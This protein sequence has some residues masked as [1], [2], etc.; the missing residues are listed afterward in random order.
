[1]LNSLAL[2]GYLK[3]I[4]MTITSDANNDVYGTL[5]DNVYCAG[6]G[7]TALTNTLNDLTISV[8]VPPIVLL[9]NTPIIEVF[10]LSVVEAKILVSHIPGGIKRV[11]KLYTD[12]NDT[13]LLFD[14]KE[15]IVIILVVC[16]VFV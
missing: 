3:N 5:N 13:K 4:L 12:T 11:F 9:Y 2:W 16:P 8:S 7:E 14:D 10:K 15:G 6:V 1:L